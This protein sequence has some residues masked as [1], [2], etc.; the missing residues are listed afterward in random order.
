MEVFVLIKLIA[1]HVHALLVLLEADV[2]QRSIYV[3][4]QIL[5]AITMDYV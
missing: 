2:N 3:C 4:K 1:I 5:L